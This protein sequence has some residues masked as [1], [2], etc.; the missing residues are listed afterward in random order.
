MH[1]AVAY[2]ATRDQR[3]VQ[4]MM[5]MGILPGTDIELLR[6]FPS[7][8]FQAGYSQF[9]VDAALARIIYVHW[10]EGDAGGV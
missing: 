4:K 5:A 8:V 1:G 2:L 6:R 7:Y 9:T 3:D 10:G